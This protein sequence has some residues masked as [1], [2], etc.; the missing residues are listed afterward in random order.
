MAKNGILKVG[1]GLGSDL[2]IIGSLN[3][4]MMLNITLYEHSEQARTPHKN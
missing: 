4:N 1:F 2:I 3:I